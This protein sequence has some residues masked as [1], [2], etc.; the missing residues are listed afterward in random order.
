MELS[1]SWVAA[2]ASVSGESVDV[3]DRLLSVCSLPLTPDRSSPARYRHVADPW[4]T[5]VV[6][7]FEDMPEPPDPAKFTRLAER[8]HALRSVVVGMAEEDAKRLV[9]GEGCKWRAYYPHR[10]RQVLTAD[11]VPY[12]LTVAI[13]DGRVDEVTFVG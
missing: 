6:L 13:R 2:R 1:G 4:R 9:E 10:G 11:R 7:T 8:A 5:S 12:R 3:I